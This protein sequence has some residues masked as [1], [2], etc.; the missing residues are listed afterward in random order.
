MVVTHTRISGRTGFATEHAGSVHG[1]VLGS[2][3]A[4]SARPDVNPR[5]DAAATYERILGLIR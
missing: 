5:Y 2:G 1:S 3:R 4:G